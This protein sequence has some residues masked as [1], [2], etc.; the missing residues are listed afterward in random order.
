MFL[1]QE[2]WA[3]KSMKSA[4]LSFHSFSEWPNSSLGLSFGKPK[5]FAI[6]IGSLGLGSHGWR[7]GL[8]WLSS[9]LTAP[10]IVF[11]STSC[12]PC[13]SAYVQCSACWLAFLEGLQVSGLR[14][15]SGSSPLLRGATHVAVRH[16]CRSLGRMARESWTHFYQKGSL[17]Q[18][19]SG[20][21]MFSPRHSVEVHCHLSSEW[22]PVPWAAATHKGSID[23]YLWTMRLQDPPWNS[24]TYSIRPNWLLFL[25]YLLRPNCQ[26][27]DSSQPNSF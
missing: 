3:T 15:S 26:N 11:G 20:A 1:L 16:P 9:G 22:P 27:Q 19:F 6:P 17:F 24:F 5:W 23:P 25:E 13:W 8:P 10:G 14:S 21:E 2:T 7:C 12:E 4:R 18:V